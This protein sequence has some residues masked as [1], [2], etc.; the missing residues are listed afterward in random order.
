MKSL[1]RDH[2]ISFRCEASYRFSRATKT[3]QTTI[4]K[5]SRN[6]KMDFKL[7]RGFVRSRNT[8]LQI[9]HGS[10]TAVALR[11]QGSHHSRAKVIGSQKKIIFSYQRNFFGYYFL[12]V[13]MFLSLLVLIMIP[14]FISLKYNYM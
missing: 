9:A 5:S 2:V 10:R 1:K 6:D 11:K 12:I 3:F 13:C 14:T 4:S 7:R 8:A